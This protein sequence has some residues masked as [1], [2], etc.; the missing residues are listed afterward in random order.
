MT[1]WLLFYILSK[2]VSVGIAN[3]SIHPCFVMC[4]NL[5]CLSPFS[6]DTFDWIWLADHQ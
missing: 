5:P 3:L 6:A 2:V 1:Q 4:V